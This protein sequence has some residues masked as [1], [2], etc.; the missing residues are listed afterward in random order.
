MVGSVHYECHTFGDGAK[1]ADNQF[2]A[3]EFIKMCDVFLK[4]LR[5]VDIVVISIVTDDY[6]RILNNILYVAKTWNIG[7][8][9]WLVFIGKDFSCYSLH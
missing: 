1:I 2:V 5:T 4:A 7:I 9:K 3:I 8:G 6:S